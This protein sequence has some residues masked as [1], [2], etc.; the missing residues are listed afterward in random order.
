[1]TRVLN[2]FAE[3]AALA[4]ASSMGTLATAIA[5]SFLIAN[6]SED[7]SFP[8]FDIHTRLIANSLFTARLAG[9]GRSWLIFMSEAVMEQIISQPTAPW[10][11]LISRRFQPLPSWINRV[12]WFSTSERLTSLSMTFLPFSQIIAP[13]SDPNRMVA[14]FSVGA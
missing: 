11:T 8:T 2:L 4:S 5:A 13:S 6:E 12:S 9:S 1:M 3:V 7:L 14:S 10:S